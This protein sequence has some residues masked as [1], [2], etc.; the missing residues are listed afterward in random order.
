[1]K[2]L[3]PFITLAVSII[4]LLLPIITIIIYYYVLETGQ[5]ADGRRGWSG[6]GSG[7]GPRRRATIW[8]V[9]AP[10]PRLATVLPRPAGKG[11]SGRLNLQPHYSGRDWQYAQPDSKAYP[12]CQLNSERKNIGVVKLL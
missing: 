5:L 1:M 4:M 3:L 7:A 11:G 12:K 2:L 9:Q 10:Q 8:P 6:R